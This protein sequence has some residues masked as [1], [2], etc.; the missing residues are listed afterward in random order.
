MGMSFGGRSGQCPA[1]ERVG[2]CL[3]R[4][5]FYN[6]LSGEDQAEVVDTISTFDC[7]ATA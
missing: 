2:D 7:W 1:T 6:L 5:P 4:L 3:V